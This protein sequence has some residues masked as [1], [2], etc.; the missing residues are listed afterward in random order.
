MNEQTQSQTVPLDDLMLA[1]DVVDT[2]RHRESLVERELRADAREQDLI[3]KVKAI[4]AGQGIEVSDEIVAEGVKALREERFSYTPPAPGFKTR[5]AY[6]YID[7][8]KWAKR[9]AGAIAALFVVWGAYY[10]FVQ[11]PEQRAVK[12]EVTTLTRAVREAQGQLSDLVSRL[13]TLAADLNQVQRQ[14]PSS[15]SNVFARTEEQTKQMLAQAA[16]RI[17]TA[18]ET[19]PAGDTRESGQARAVIRTRLGQQTA[20]LKD[21][22]TLLDQAQGNLRLL[23]LMSV[24]PGE[25]A[26]LESSVRAIS[27][28]TE[29]TGLADRFRQ[30]ALAALAQGD[31]TTA[32]RRSSDLKDILARLQQTYTLRIVSRPG[33]RSGVWRYPE[34]NTGARNYYVIVEAVTDNGERLTLPITSEEDG[35][36]Y[37]VDRWGLRV[38]KAVYDRVAADKQ[39]DGIIQRNIFGVKRRG[40]LHPEYAMPTSGAAITQW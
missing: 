29:A 13:K 12:H 1:M 37:N 11:L 6:W 27:Q 39:D 2:L 7:R 3:E 30:D 28:D 23:N 4:Y 32:Q 14:V 15:L 17:Q 10:G 20:L 35:R 31:L 19:V 33:E 24:L 8:G 36:V 21:A 38:D 9:A 18:S 16:Q 5:V 34:I 22:E 25:L 40:F 26:Q